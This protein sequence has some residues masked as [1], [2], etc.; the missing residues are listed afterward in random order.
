MTIVLMDPCKVAIQSQIQRE[1]AI[2]HNTLMGDRRVA[3]RIAR[4][5]ENQLFFVNV[6]WGMRE[7]QDGVEDVYT[8]GE[9]GS[10][11]G[12]AELPTGINTMLTRCYS[13]I[14]EEG[15]V[16][17]SYTC[18]RKVLLLSKDDSEGPEGILHRKI[19]Y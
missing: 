6:D 12:R 10:I 14:C 13:A 9:A 7:L 15:V 5:L 19:K 4:T 3:L 1:L 8:F 17:Y 2:N 11:V 18:P 16:C